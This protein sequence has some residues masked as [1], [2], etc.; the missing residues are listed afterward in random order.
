RL[1][2]IVTEESLHTGT[3]F[4]SVFRNR[5]D[6]FIGRLVF[7]I[8]HESKLFLSTYSQTDYKRYHT[9]IL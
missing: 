8:E 2:C 7:L 1:H 6:E 3:V 4:E 9:G 5:R